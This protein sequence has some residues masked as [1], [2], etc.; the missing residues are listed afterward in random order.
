MG[1]KYENQTL[2]EWTYRFVLCATTLLAKKKKS[3]PTAAELL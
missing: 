2:S 1:K 3:S